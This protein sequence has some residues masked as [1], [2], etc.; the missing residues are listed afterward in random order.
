MNEPLESRSSTARARR[1]PSAF[2]APPASS[3]PPTWSHEPARASIN[4]CVSAVGRLRTRFTEPPG[5]PAPSNRPCAPR[6][7][8]TR[9]RYA[10]LPVKLLPTA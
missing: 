5:C 7:T 1:L 3:M 10:V 8:S 6:N 2:K 4:T 9:S